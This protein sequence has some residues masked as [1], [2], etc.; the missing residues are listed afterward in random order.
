MSIVS[1]V[2]TKGRR[3]TEKMTNWQTDKK[4]EIRPIKLCKNYKK[5]YIF[6]IA[7]DLI[8]EQFYIYNKDNPSIETK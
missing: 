4:L 7:H 2:L 3:K 5:L 8:V 6:V 1:K